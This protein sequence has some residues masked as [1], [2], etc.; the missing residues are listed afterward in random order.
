MNIKD[1]SLW[2][3]IARSISNLLWNLIIEYT[4][5]LKLPDLGTLGEQF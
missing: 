3:L 5:P 4:G 1:F 2:P